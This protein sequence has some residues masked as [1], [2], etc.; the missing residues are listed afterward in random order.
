MQRDDIKTFMKEIKSIFPAKSFWP[1]VIA[2]IPI[3]FL[4]SLI[5][6][7][8]KDSAF[9]EFDG[10]QPTKWSRD[11]PSD[12]C[13][14]TEHKNCH[15]SSP[16]IV[17]LN[18][19]Q[20]LDIVVATNNG[21]IIAF[22]HNGATL[23]DTDVAPAFGM[24]AGTNLIQ[25]SPAVADIDGD[26][27]LEIVVGT[28]ATSADVCTMGGVIVLDHF[29]NI[30]VGWPRLSFGQNENGCTKTIYSSPALGDLDRDGD[31]E[32]VAAGFDGRI[33]AW[34]HDG[35]LLP[36]FPPDSNHR[37]RFPTWKDLVG[38][39]ADSVWSSPTLSDINNDGFL[40]IIIG[41]DEGNFDAQWGGDARGWTCPY[42]LPAG[43]APGY[44]GGSIYALDRF[45]KVVPGFPLYLLEA[46]QST[47]AIIDVDGDGRSEMFFGTGTFY[48][49]NSPDHP[50]NGFKVYGKDGAGNDL[51]G[52]TTTTQAGTVS[53]KVIGGATPSSPSIGDIAG[54]AQPEIVM[55]SMDKKLYAWHLD[56]SEVNGFPMSPLDHFGKPLGGF[57]V[58]NTL[59]L[60]N[61]DQDD[62]MEIFFNQAWVVSIVDG[63][64]E[65]LT[66]TNYP[67]DNNPV[68]FTNGTLANTP[69]VA[70]I[71]KDGRLELIASNS[72]LYVWDLQANSDRSAW[73]MF[74]G[75]P[76]RTGEFPQPRL[77]VAPD[78]LV[79]YSQTGDEG[80]A[81]TDLRI[82]NIGTGSFEW[83]AETPQELSISQDFGTLSSSESDNTTVIISTEGREEGE[84]FLGNITINA[85][86]EVGAVKNA[87]ESISVRLIVGDFYRTFTPLIGN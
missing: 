23:W 86:M 13:P 69:I 61:Y 6:A 4:A 30:E 78:D 66:S 50:T 26:G 27:K 29:G 21:H 7:N 1:N 67:N 84:Y 43:W 9:A 5:G 71:D 14:N 40:E 85:T 34:D 20:M 49:N 76:A 8:G 38:R 72:K 31:M 35:S 60:A 10:F 41:T 54:D 65:Q 87:Q 33:Y 51:P 3:L 77:K 83:T 47:P 68:Y 79:L 19:D 59:I 44:C 64:G 24:K 11:L 53:G 39:L 57:D 80:V 81:K 62:K 82:Q 36:G 55:L 32:I 58:G 17:D 37:I 12:F 63:N 25:S 16:V 56:G 2:F 18:D 15:S 45:G 73:P 22:D 70:D 42:Q 52:W 28:G 46:V 75:N 74:K 48:H